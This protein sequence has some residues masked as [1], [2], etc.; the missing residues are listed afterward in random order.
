MGNYST[1]PSQDDH[2]VMI[3]VRLCNGM[4]PFSL[5]LAVLTIISTQTPVSTFHDYE[6]RIHRAGGG[7]SLEGWHMVQH[8]KYKSSSFRRVEVDWLCIH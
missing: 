4:P 5:Q 8:T 6:E 2:G 7:L 1:Y 3:T